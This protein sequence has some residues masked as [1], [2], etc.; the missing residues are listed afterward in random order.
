[1][2]DRPST[3]FNPDRLCHHRIISITVAQRQLNCQRTSRRQARPRIS[4]A[5]QESSTMDGRFEYSTST[6]IC[7][8]RLD[9]TGGYFSWTR[10][11]SIAR[12]RSCMPLFATLG[13]HKPIPKP[14]ANLGSFRSRSTLCD[15]LSHCCACSME[16]SKTSTWPRLTRCPT[17]SLV[18]AYLICCTFS[19]PGYRRG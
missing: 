6:G 17:W 7:C 1:M 16:T 14:T 13:C 19:D 10:T 12:R 2:V 8:S 3:A 5:S 11:L 9:Q 15:P 4:S 18:W